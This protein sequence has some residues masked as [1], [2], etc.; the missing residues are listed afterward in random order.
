MQLKQKL[1]AS[2]QTATTNSIFAEEA[3]L[4][5]AEI[6]KHRIAAEAQEKLCRQQLEAAQLEN[7]SL[8]KETELLKQQLIETQQLLA[9]MDRNQ[10]ESTM[11]LERVTMER[12]VLSEEKCYLEHERYELKQRLKETIEENSK[13]KENEISQRFRTEAAEEALEKATSLHYEAERG[14]RFIE[15]EK[16]ERE[17][18][19]ALW[20][21][22]YNALADLVHSQ[23]EEKS[24][25]QNKAVCNILIFYW[26]NLIIKD[27]AKFFKV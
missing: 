12:D 20:M 22:K 10:F 25:R 4:A 1:N 3:S 19:C 14:R 6:E 2:Q 23:E 26:Q 18:Q 8:K 13:C 17:K 24:K 9:Q 27:S 11:K 15:H 21:E 7:I 16:E 5:Q